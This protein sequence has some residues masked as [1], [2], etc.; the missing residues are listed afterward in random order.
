MSG[1][2]ENQKTIRQLK[3]MIGEIKPNR[4]EANF[5]FV[6][7][8]PKSDIGKGT[9]VA[10]L[11]NVVDNSDAIKYDGLLNTNAN[12]RHTAVGHDDFGIYEK[13][14]SGR[15]WGREHYLLGG[16]IYKEFIENYGENENLQI[17]PHLSYFVE[18]KIYDLWQKSGRPKNFFIEVGGLITDPEVDPIFTPI[19]QRLAGDGIGKVI[20]LTE[21]SYGEYIKTKTIQEAY[22]ALISRQITTW[23]LVAREPIEVGKI[24]ESERFEFERVISTKLYSVFNNRLERII[25]VPYFKDLKK[26]TKYIKS[27]FSPL[28]GIVDK[29]SIFVGTNNNSKLDDYRIYI[30]NEY[31]IRSPKTDKIKLDIKEGIDSIEDNAIA[32]ARAYAMKTGLISIGDDTGF[33][34]KELNGEP[35]VALRRWGG[36][37]PEATDNVAFWKIL[38]AKTKNLKNYDCYFKQCVAVV[39]PHGEVEIIYNINNGFLNTTKLKRPYNN[40]GYPLGAAFESYNRHK[41]WDEMTDDEKRDFDKR[42]IDELRA[43]IEKLKHL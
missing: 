17:N 7:G 13:F 26:Y 27:R 39:S 29:K 9:L 21:L 3:M 5:Y 10:Q 1:L 8:F 14:N 22:Q 37:L 12:G 43:K 18:H 28:I 6:L 42:F 19:I 11:L 35:G 31:N 38:Q 20:L 24:T 25:S 36:E 2:Y 15:R 30:G 16:E 32:K 23:L 33:F 4:N 34:I 41:T 40:S